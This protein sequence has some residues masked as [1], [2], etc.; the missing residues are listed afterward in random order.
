MKAIEPSS[1]YF[2][3]PNNLTKIQKALQDVEQEYAVRILVA[4]EAGSRAW[5]LAS[6]TSDFDVKFIYAH[7]PGWY[8]RLDEG[9]RDVIDKSLENGFF[10]LNERLSR[11]YGKV[12]GTCLNG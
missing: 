7:T 5:G 10:D 11:C 2:I 8:M 4:T 12:T 3:H 1:P 6:P 9:Q